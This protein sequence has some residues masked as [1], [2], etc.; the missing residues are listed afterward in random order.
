M[1]FIPLY[2]GEG[3]FSELHE[4]LVDL[5]FSLRN[6]VPSYVHDGRSL[7]GDAIYSRL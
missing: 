4:M 3:L 2:E 6:I 1:N 7:S 5:G